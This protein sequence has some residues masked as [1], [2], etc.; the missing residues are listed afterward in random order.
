MR[1]MINMLSGPLRSRAWGLLA[2]LLLA[3]TLAGCHVANV[4]DEFGYPIQGVAVR[5]VYL[6]HEGPVS[7]TGADGKAAVNID[8]RPTSLRFAKA[9]YVGGELAFDEWPAYAVMREDR[10]IVDKKQ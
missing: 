9:G 6:D 8:G 10:V 7:L 1:R 5:A 2:G 4:R 3:A